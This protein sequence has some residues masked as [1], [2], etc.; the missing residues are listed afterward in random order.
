M[1]SPTAT[2]VRETCGCSKPRRRRSIVVDTGRVEKKATGLK[3]TAGLGLVSVPNSWSRPSW[4]ALQT[5]IRAMG[6]VTRDYG[7][8]EERCVCISH[9]RNGTLSHSRSLSFCPVFCPPPFSS[10]RGRQLAHVCSCPFRR[11]HVGSGQHTNLPGSFAVQ[12]GTARQ[13]GHLEKELHSF[14]CSSPDKGSR[15]RSMV[16]RE[17]GR[18]R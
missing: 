14:I 10:G 18:R 15:R 7:I 4:L 9:L 13:L 8:E 12:A 1:C 17:L 6:A 3:R 2:G 5:A 16:P 11:Q